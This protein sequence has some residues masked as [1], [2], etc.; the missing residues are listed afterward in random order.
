MYGEQILLFAVPLVVLGVL[1]RW[2]WAGE[3]EPDPW[4][5]VK[6]KDENNEEEEQICQRCL[7]LTAPGRLFCPNCGASVDS[8]T[9]MMPWVSA[10][11]LGDVM[12]SGVHLGRHPSSIVRIGFLLTVFAVVIVYFPVGLF[13]FAPAYLYLYFR[14]S[15]NQAAS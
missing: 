9:A 12:R 15:R 14:N 13:L 2:F 1:Y 8:V 5:Q 6:D 10:L 3:I 7:N 11:A 4:E